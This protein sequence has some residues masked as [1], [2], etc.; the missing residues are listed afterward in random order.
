MDQTKR[1]SCFNIKNWSVLMIVETYILFLQKAKTKDGEKST[2]KTPK[3]LSTQKRK[4]QLLNKE[5]KQKKLESALF[6]E[7]YVLCFQ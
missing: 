2:S 3:E 1:T 5:K 4:K 7:K 6:G